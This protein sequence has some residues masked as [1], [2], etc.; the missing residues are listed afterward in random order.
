[1][2]DRPLFVSFYTAQAMAYGGLMTWAL[3]GEAPENLL[4][5]LYPKS[6]ET[7]PDG[8]PE[9][10]TTMYY[11]REFSAIYKH[12]EHEGL[13]GGLGHLAANKASGVIGLTREWASGVNSFGQEIRDPDAPAYKKLEQT[14][15]HTLTELEPISVG[16]IREQVTQSPIKSAL[17]NIS[18]FGPAPRY[19][20]ATNTES[21]IRGTYQKYFSTTQ[22][23]FDKAQF[24]N[25]RR[26][27]KKH[28]EN[29][30]QE[31]FGETLD[32]M[33]EKYE[34]T[35][36]ELRKLESS[37]TSGEDPLLTMFQRLT[38]KQQKKILDQMTEEERDIYLPMSNKEHV[39]YSYEPP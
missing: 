15:L 16:A 30:D 19:V 9:R 25:D 10:L 17:L 5:Y 7:K 31:A 23:S 32:K 39:R 4:D 3:S 2:L 36:K 34:L 22:T 33:Q 1:M 11:P 24:S 29:G 13:V 38:W 8:Q 27:L 12:I 26:T 35:G 6:G 28:F 18:G 20:T 14:L 37:L 21:L